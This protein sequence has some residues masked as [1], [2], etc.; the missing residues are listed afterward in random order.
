MPFPRALHVIALLVVV[1]IIGFWPSYFAGAEDVPMAFHFHGIAS[2]AWIILVGFQVWSI[3]NGHRSLHRQTGLLSLFL[4]PVFTASLVMIANVSAADY[5]AGGAYESVVGPVFGYATLIPLLAYPVIFALALQ[6]RRNVY[7]H[8]GYMLATLFP[9][10]EPGFVRILIRFVP[11]MAI[12]GPKDFHK[13]IDGIALS[14]TMALAVAVYMYLRDR[15][16]GTPFLIVGVFLAL[17][18]AGCYLVADTELW[19]QWF[20]SYARIPAGITV[21]TGFLIG[22]I[23]AW[24]GWSQ[25]TKQSRAA[26]AE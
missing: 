16:R 1:T 24:I 19:R 11:A 15:R 7:L 9:L 26:V 4:L 22:A 2:S 10:W 8:A 21:G 25:P 13:A 5:V 17:Q 3:Q 6:H 23:A 14:I 12:N 20:E 18:I